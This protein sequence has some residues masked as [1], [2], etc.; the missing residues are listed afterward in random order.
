MTF[1]CCYPLKKIRFHRAAFDGNSS[2][3]NQQFKSKIY[4]MTKAIFCRFSF[5]KE[6]QEYLERFMFSEWRNSSMYVHQF[7]TKRLLLFSKRE[8]NSS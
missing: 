4:E 5:W 3:L 7:C 2:L 8:Q 1:S 6:E